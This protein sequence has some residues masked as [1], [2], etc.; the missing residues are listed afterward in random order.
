MKKRVISVLTAAAALTSLAA[1]CGSKGGSSQETVSQNETQAESPSDEPETE[2]TTEA[3]MVKEPFV[4]PDVDI[5][6]MRDITTMEL[7][8]EMGL[9]INLGNTFEACGGWINGNSV[10]D[11]EVAW[12]S[13]IITED[14][15]EGYA[16]EGFGVLRVPVAWSNLM[17]E[18]YTIDPT[19]I[20]RVHEVVGWALEDG[21]Y[22]IMNIHWDGGWWEDFPTDTDECMK[23]Y[24]A[25]WTQ[26]CD[27]FGDYGD[28]L[29]FESLN[30]EGGWESLWNRYSGSTEGKDV[31]Y[32]LLNDINQQFV[33][34]VRGSGGNN[35]ERHLLIAGYNT[36]IDLTCDPL[37]VMPDDPAGRCAVSVHYYTPSTFCILDADADWGKAKTSWGS[38]RDKAELEGYMDKVKETFIDKGIPVIVGE[39]G[40]V[41]IKN[42]TPEEIRNY[43]IAVVQTAY[44]RGICMVLWDITDVFYDRTACEFKDQEML[45]GMLGAAGQT[46]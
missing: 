26:L 10:S 33:D 28:R 12:G 3:G 27:A 32:Q 21:L 44:D 41:A 22:V 17:A 42:K 31:S 30:E 14:I 29:M 43:N 18:D 9:G 16:A 13:P 38:P 2:I 6:E 39:F 19:Y 8:K 36:D 25:I 23:K 1:G 40:A 46:G 37:F 7:V 11:Y 45:A 4:K 34:V 35:A 24:T 15:I 5:T 20:A